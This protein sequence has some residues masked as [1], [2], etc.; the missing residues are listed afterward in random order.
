M[1]SLLGLVGLSR[2]TVFDTFNNI[3]CLCA[4]WIMFGWWESIVNAS[5][6]SNRSSFDFVTKWNIQNITHTRTQYS[7]RWN[8]LTL[9][10][11]L[12]A[13]FEHSFSHFSRYLSVSFSLSLFLSPSLIPRCY[14]SFALNEYAHKAWSVFSIQY[15]CYEYCTFHLV[16]FI[17]R[18]H[19]AI[20]LW[21]NLYRCCTPKK[22][23]TVY[24]VCFDEHHFSFVN[25]CVCVD[26]DIAMWIVPK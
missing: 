16:R 20:A 26:F 9:W 4:C 17:T 13:A 3:H 5:F 23:S 6:E 21:D 25:G 12:F 18:L 22:W 2:F 1:E 10:L 24:F 11:F 7:I 8:T 19:W 14:L 15:L